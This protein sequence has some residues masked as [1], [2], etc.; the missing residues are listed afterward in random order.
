MKIALSLALLAVIGAS[1]FAA[2]QAPRT[3]TVTATVPQ[4]APTPQGGSLPN[5][6]SS[7]ELPLLPEATG[8][9]TLLSTITLGTLYSEKGDA[10]VQLPLLNPPSVVHGIYL[11][12]W[13]AGSPNRLASLIKLA[14]MT[15]I[16]AMVID[17]KDYSGYVSYRMN[18]P[19]VK[20]AGALNQ[21]RIAHPNSMIKVLHDNGI[22]AIARVTVFQDPILAK[23]RPE[24]AL[25]KK[26]SDAVWFDNHGLAW[27]DPSAPPVW[28]YVLSIANDAYA[29]G[30][31][32][33]NFDYVRF[34]SDGSLQT[35]SYPFWNGVTPRHEVLAKFFAYVND[36]ERD[37]VVSADLFGL[38]TINTDDLGIGQIIQDAYANFD[39]VA[40][41]IYPSHYAAGM[42]GYQNPADHPYEIIHYSLVNALKKLNGKNKVS[43]STRTTTSTSTLPS[44]TT[45]TGFDPF[46]K[47]R[48]SRLTTSTL[49]ANSTPQFQAKLRPWIQVFNLGAVYTSAM[50][51]KELQA[52][53][54]V[55]EASTT[56]AGYGGWLLWDPNNNYDSYREFMTRG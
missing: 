15:N 21:I 39:Y 56:V 19:G 41:M 48:A 27:L 22:Y 55:L 20:A 7:P 35:I 32:E 17:I 49:G 12:G 36:H 53:H 8:T 30:F 33:V 31:D 38:A 54:D 4:P 40:P 47:L 28:D 29:R 11:T 9:Q 16:N 13:T 42:L 14:K 51:G 6:S 52:V 50:V 46:D 43:S 25:K 34:P 44:M 45:S 26:G 37:R 5:T 2:A 1:F 24:W 3:I 18:V 23:A 10:P